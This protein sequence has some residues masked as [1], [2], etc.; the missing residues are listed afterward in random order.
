[1]NAPATMPSEVGLTSFLAKQ[2]AAFLR[3]GAPTFDQRM[4]DLTTL[5]NAVPTPSQRLPVLDRPGLIGVSSPDDA[6]PSS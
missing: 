3:E 2:R 5:K 1:M 4:A 6:A